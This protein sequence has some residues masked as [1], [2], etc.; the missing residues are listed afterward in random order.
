MYIVIFYGEK[1]GNMMNT[2][3]IPIKIWDPL[4]ID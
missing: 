1:G 3:H 4:I 2:N